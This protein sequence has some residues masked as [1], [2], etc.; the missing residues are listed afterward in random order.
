LHDKDLPDHGRF[1]L[2]PC[3]QTQLADAIAT[4]A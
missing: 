2:K 1:L 4:E 3:Q